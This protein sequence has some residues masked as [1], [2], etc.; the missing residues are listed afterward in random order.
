M[1]NGNDLDQAVELVLSSELASAD[2]QALMRQLD[3]ELQQQTEAQSLVLGGDEPDAWVLGGD[4]GGG[5]GS[6]AQRF[7]GFYADAIYKEICDPEQGQ[8]KD[9]YRNLIGGS[10]TNDRV[11][12]IAPAVL[13][14]I[15]I[16]ASLVNPATIAAIVAL[17]LVK[18]GLDQW[19]AVPRPAATPAPSSEPTM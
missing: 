17:W 12:Q 2:E 19:C 10:D 3:A 14:A 1:S 18:L 16:G 5:F 13:A 7:I 9:T 6:M 4:H 15:G 11:K 8:L